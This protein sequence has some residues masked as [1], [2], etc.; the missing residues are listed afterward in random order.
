MLK[1]YQVNSQMVKRPLGRFTEQVVTC[2]ASK[3]FEK[4]RFQLQ[5]SSESWYDHLAKPCS[6]IEQPLRS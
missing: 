4:E 5:F 3:A 1:L 2:D 6:L